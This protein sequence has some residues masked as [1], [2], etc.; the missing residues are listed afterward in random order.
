MGYF[1]EKSKPIIVKNDA[2]I[3]ICVSEQ[4]LKNERT[5][6]PEKGATAFVASDVEQTSSLKRELGSHASSIPTVL[7]ADCKSEETSSRGNELSNE[8]QDGTHTIT[9]RMWL[10]EW[11]ILLCSTLFMVALTCILGVFNGRVIPTLYGGINI[12]TIVSLLATGMHIALGMLF[13]TI[14]GALRFI[15]YC[16]ARSLEDLDLFGAAGQPSLDTIQLLG[17]ALRKYVFL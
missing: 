3:T 17:K 11:L 10:V 13:L 7:V 2:N 8:W 9:K 5:A 6:F 1:D 14:F 15:W 16:E 12:N 4:E